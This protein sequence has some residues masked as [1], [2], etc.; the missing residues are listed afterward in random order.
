MQVITAGTSGDGQN[1]E[2]QPV[3]TEIEWKNSQKTNDAISP[4]PISQ[5]YV[6]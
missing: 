6:N 4:A 1:E 3:V 5:F 2:W